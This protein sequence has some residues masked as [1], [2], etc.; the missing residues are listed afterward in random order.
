MH[1]NVFEFVAPHVFKS[2]E[3]DVFVI[4]DSVSHFLDMGGFVFSRRSFGRFGEMD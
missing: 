2:K 4:V 3:K 1:S